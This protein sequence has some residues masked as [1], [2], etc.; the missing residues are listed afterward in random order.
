ME[1]KPLLPL[2]EESTINPLLISYQPP[3]QPPYQC[4]NSGHMC[5]IVTLLKVLI[6]SFDGHIDIVKIQRSEIDSIPDKKVRT[7]VCRFF[8]LNELPTWYWG[9]EICFKEYIEW[10]RDSR[11]KKRWV[12]DNPVEYIE[13]YLGERTRKDLRKILEGK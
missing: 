4:A 2:W 12:V 1:R 3:Y 13:A 8:Y 6:N 7:W 5:K 10:L 9:V 11:A